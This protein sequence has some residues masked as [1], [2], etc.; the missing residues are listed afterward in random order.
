MVIAGHRLGPAQSLNEVE[1]WC[2]AL[3]VSHDSG[4]APLM[5]ALTGY[6]THSV[7]HTMKIRSTDL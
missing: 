2:T 7:A 5:Y 1:P 4:G 3:M 6:L